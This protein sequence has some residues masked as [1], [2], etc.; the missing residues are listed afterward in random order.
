MDRYELA[1][2][3]VWKRPK[4]NSIDHRKQ[5]GVCTD[6]E[7]KSKKYNQGEGGT[8]SYPPQAVTYVLN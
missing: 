7:G 3:R 6:P 5:G 2:L 4:Q 8:L 1:R